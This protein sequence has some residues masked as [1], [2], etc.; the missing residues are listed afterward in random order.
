VAMSET[1]SASGRQPDTATPS[2]YQPGQWATHTP[3]SDPGRYA[4]LL[5]AV[6][7]TIPELSEVARNIIIHYR[8]ADLELPEATKYDIN[9]RWVSAILALDQQRHGRPLDAERE[10]RSRVQGC[11]RDHSLF[12]AAVLRQHGVPARIRYGFAHYFIPDYNVDHVIVETWLPDEQRWLRFDPEV[13]APMERI[14]TPQD[15]PHG[16]DAPFMTAAE[17]WQAY[18]AGTIDPQTYG[19]GPGTPIGGDWFI[20]G[21]VLYDAA[22]RAG[23]ELLLWDGWAA[24]SSPDGVTDAEGKLADE[25]SELIIAAD[26]GDNDAERQL[27]ERVRTDPKVGPPTVVNTLSPY[28]DP[29]TTTDLGNGP[30]AAS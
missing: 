19:V 27:I 26:A 9:A 10:P 3:F 24:Q 25:L 17:A 28:G 30:G 23:L 4:E 21:S 20:Q 6:P 18:R 11:C 13:G 12:G 5:A 29:P 8:S 2:G 1:L 14:A 7:P 22:F 16:P 15:I